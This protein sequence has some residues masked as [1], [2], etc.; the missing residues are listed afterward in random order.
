MPAS[1]LDASWPVA[2]LPGLYVLVDYLVNEQLHATCRDPQVVKGLD[3]PGFTGKEEITHAYLTQHGIEQQR[4]NP[5]LFTKQLDL[6]ELLGLIKFVHH[7]R[8]QYDLMTA[9]CI[10]FTR[11]VVKSL[12]NITMWSEMC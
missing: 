2:L 6:G 9:N 7:E 10:W 3:I 1:I 11:K 12:I 5:I 4:L 8:L